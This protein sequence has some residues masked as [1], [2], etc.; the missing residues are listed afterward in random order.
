VILELVNSFLD[1][2]GNIGIRTAKILAALGG[3]PDQD[4]LCISRGGRV[5]GEGIRCIGMGPLG[6]FPRVL[7]AARIFLS[8]GFNHRTADIWMFTRFAETVLAAM[9]ASKYSLSHV[10]EYAPAL[11]RA[12]KRKG[13][14]VILDVPI[15]PTAYAERLKKE[16]RYLHG[17]I[18]SRQDLIEREAFALADR[19]IVPSEFV[20]EELERIGVPGSRMRLVHFGV[21]TPPTALRHASGPVNDDPGLASGIQ[22]VLLGNVNYRKGVAELLEVF[23][24]PVFAADRL[25]LCGRVNPEVGDLLDRAGPHVL[26][27]GFV[28]PSRYLQRCHVFVMPS[29]MEGS[30]KAVFE[31]MAMGLPC[32]VSKSTG[33]IVRDGMDGY[34]V[35]AGDVSAL[36]AVMLKMKRNPEKMVV[37]GKNAMRRASGFSWRRYTDGVISVYR[38][39]AE[40]ARL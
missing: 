14:P 31:A 20:A 24:D 26:T 34:I 22:W 35:D 17:R 5:N 36:R 33:S 23:S 30:S 7:N 11:M 25:H 2:P 15:A 12:L 9:P 32:I 8:P 16:G 39:V 40:T 28:N 3:L 4:A 18:F 1:R 19:L 37:M 38:E 13:I 6:H 10:W 29:W 27:P 21:D